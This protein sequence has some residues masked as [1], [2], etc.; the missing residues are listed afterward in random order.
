MTTA[1]NQLGG[2]AAPVRA[3]QPPRNLL[4]TATDL[5]FLAMILCAMIPR[6]LIGG[7]PEIFGVPVYAIFYLMGLQLLVFE[8]LFGRRGLNV[9][10]IMTLTLCAWFGIVGFFNGHEKMAIA[11]DIFVF[12]SIAAGMAWVRSR[13]A[14]VIVRDFQLLIFL[15]VSLLVIILAGLAIG[16]IP[17]RGPNSARIYVLALFVGTWP[18]MLLCPFLLAASKVVDDRRWGKAMRRIVPFALFVF[19]AI[20]LMTATRSLFISAVMCLIMCI[21]VA[22]LRY[23][24]YAIFGTAV[25]AIVC[26]Y[27]YTVFTIE[28]KTEYML[29]ARLRRTAQLQKETRYIEA[30]AIIK[31]R[32]GDLFLGAGFGDSYALPKQGGSAFAEFSQ[33][34][35]GRASDTLTYH[36]HIG[37]LAFLFKGGAVLLTLYIL[38]PLIFAVKVL[39]WPGSAPMRVGAMAGVF[40]YIVRA[41][42]SGGWSTTSLILYGCLWGIASRS[43][44]R[45]LKS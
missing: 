40:L 24:A 1:A 42:M 44:G 37:A 2:A 17:S 23:K 39:C 36:P 13:D 25:V 5:C 30:Q 41:S 32:G 4:H 19:A 33:G 31:N 14:S 8:Y 12:I 15:L 22:G 43:F 9:L 34:I 6:T 16:I 21:R 18:I 45:E 3:A 28:N 10:T 38:V 26:W 11:K 35:Y 27:T 7:R 20:A 29:S